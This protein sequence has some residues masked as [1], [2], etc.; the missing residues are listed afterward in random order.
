MMMETRS[1]DKGN[2]IGPI[3]REDWMILQML[4]RTIKYMQAKDPARYADSIEFE[5]AW[6]KELKD[7]YGLLN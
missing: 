2:V 6:Q 3:S 1:P 7:K 5:K 4:Q